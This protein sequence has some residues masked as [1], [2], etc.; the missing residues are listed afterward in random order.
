MGCGAEAVP[1]D[2]QDVYETGETEDGVYLIYPAGA[3]HPLPVYCDMTTDNSVWTVGGVGCVGRTQVPEPCHWRCPI[4]LRGQ[5]GPHEAAS[6]LCDLS[7]VFQK[8]F[9]GSVSFFRGWNDYR[10]G[11]GR[12]DGEYWLG[13]G[14][15]AL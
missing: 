11:F 15:P 1:V 6:D 10:F 7:Q 14:G 4:H 5:V 13:T 8:R 2:C 9:N 12:A 3:S